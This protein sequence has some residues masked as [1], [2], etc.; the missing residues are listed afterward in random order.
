MLSE[1]FGTNQED[2]DAYAE[3]TAIILSYKIK[4]KAK[5]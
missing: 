3:L 2:S 5:G 4:K 1:E